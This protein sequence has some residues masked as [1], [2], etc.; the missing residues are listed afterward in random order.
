MNLL[1]RKTADSVSQTTKANSYKADSNRSSLVHLYG[2]NQQNALLS[3]YCKPICR[4]NGPG[5]GGGGKPDR[6]TYQKQ[7]RIG[8]EY[9]FY[10]YDDPNAYIL[11]YR[12]DCTLTSSSKDNY[13]KGP[14]ENVNKSVVDGIN[15][16]ENDNNYY[17][18]NK[19][20]IKR[21]TSIRMIILKPSEL[22]IS[23]SNFLDRNFMLNLQLSLIRKNNKMDV[24]L[25][26]ETE[27]KNSVF[28]DNELVSYL[29]PPWA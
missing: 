24:K 18:Y 11:Q 19:S 22:R 8:K 9:K 3:M 17:T 23:Q 16:L 6:F 21:N 20:L 14:L 27:T 4:P 2:W 28:N 26:I 12:R 13:D 15:K 1:H 7:T 10:H 29:S 25:V 5:I